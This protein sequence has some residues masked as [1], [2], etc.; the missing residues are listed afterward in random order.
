MD[1]SG[2]GRITGSGRHEHEHKHNGILYPLMVIAAVAVILFSVV[3]IATVLG[4]LPVAESRYD[5]QSSVGP[6][7]AVSAQRDASHA[8]TRRAADAAAQ[9]L[10]W[11]APGLAP[12]P[13][14]RS[15][16]T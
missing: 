8:V 12:T 6:A 16:R 7:N 14:T 2:P 5:P 9:R 11:S 13:A 4:L 10:P 15:R 1:T 3:G